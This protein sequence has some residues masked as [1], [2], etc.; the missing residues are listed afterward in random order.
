M[1]EESKF[2]FGVNLSKSQETAM[3]GLIAESSKEGFQATE[4]FKTQIDSIW[5]PNVWW[6]SGRAVGLSGH[7]CAT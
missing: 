5:L 4:S 1:T 3:S 2:K 6:M 7:P